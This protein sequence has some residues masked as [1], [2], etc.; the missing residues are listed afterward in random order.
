M[1][2]AGLTGGVASGKS[3][4]ANKFKELGA[5]LIDADVIARE[6]LCP[7]Q[8]AFNDVVEA[9]G[10]DILTDDGVIDRKKLGEVVFNDD[11]KR[12]TLNRLTHPRIRERMMARVEE[13]RR[14]STELRSPSQRLVVLVVPLLIESGLEDKVDYIIVVYADEETQLGR[15][16]E[17]DRI[18]KTEAMARIN[19]QIPLK[20]KL[21]SADY[22]ID[23]NK[24]PELTLKETARIY[25]KITASENL[26]D[27]G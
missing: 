18:T 10:K 11:E 15:L 17:R 3:L 21:K 23:N 1:I 22:I 27:R 20:K 6:V 16:M 14:S 24:E 8:P 2:V 5:V 7:G 9:F 25:L 12:S 26:G 19:S 4:V 13:L